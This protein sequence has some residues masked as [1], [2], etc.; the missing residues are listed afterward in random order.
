PRSYDLRGKRFAVVMAGNPY[1]ESG[2]VF[3]IPDML[4]NRA[5][6]Y[7]LGDVLSGREALFALSYLENSLTANP[8]LLPLSSRDP[9]DVHLL[10]QRAQG[11][12]V[13]DSQFAHPYG[14]AELEEL[15]QLF[16][17]LFRAR[18]LLLKVNLN[19]IESAAQKDDYRTEPPFKL[20]GSYRNMTKLAAQINPQ[21]RDDELDALLRDHYRGEAQTLTTG[22]EENLLKLAQL[23]GTPT[24]DETQ[25]WQAICEEFVRQR[26]LGGSDTDGSTRIATTLLD[27]AR[28]VDGLK[29]PQTAVPKPTDSEGVRL[30][31]AMLEIA[32]TYRKIL[33]PL[34]A[35]T[36]N[37]LNLDH[38]IHNE[39]ERVAKQLEDVRSRQTAPKGKGS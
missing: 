28:A 36:E 15:T 14:A 10:V 31:E 6:I 37:R 29:P 33:M 22:A 27:V 23:L 19:Y 35:A 38:S 34:I 26:K 7:N 30:A 8:V 20:Q 16:K 1:T 17:R 12:E 11:Q 32:V 24:P 4:A 25:R 21:M 5:D 13:A 9:K 3:K 18:D 2:D 39:V